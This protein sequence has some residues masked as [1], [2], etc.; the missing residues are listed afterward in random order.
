MKILAGL[1]AGLLFGAGLCISG[2][3]W[4]AKVTGF[5]DFAGAWDP[6][7]AFVMAGAVGTYAIASRII[8]RR[9][10]PLLAESFEPR[11]NNRIDARL[12]VGAGL[13]GVG[14]GLSGYCPGPALVS[15][16]SLAAITLG[17]VGAMSIGM[18]AVRRVMVAA[19]AVLA[20]TT[21]ACSG[22]V[23][24]GV[25]V[26]GPVIGLRYETLTRSGLTT[27]GGEFEYDEGETVTFS[28]G[29]VVLGTTKGAK[30]ISPF[31]LFAVTPPTSP[32]DVRNHITDGVV[33]GFDRAANV[34]LFLQALDNDRDLGNGIDVTAWGAGLA[35]FSL[36]FDESF[37]SFALRTFQDFAAAH[38]GIDRH[39]DVAS[40][41]PHVYT[42]L[43]LAVS[44]RVM[45]T[46]QV[47]TGNDGSINRSFTYGHDA[48]GR[49]ERVQSISDSAPAGDDD[50]TYD[51]RG[52]RASIVLKSDLD[53]NGTFERIESTTWTYDDDGNLV[54]ELLLD[55]T[56]G[57][58]GTKRTRTF[59]HDI[60]GNVVRIVDE[61]DNAGNGSVERRSETTSVYDRKGQRLSTRIAYDNENDGHIDRVTSDTQTFDAHGNVIEVLNTTDS[62]GD[63]AIDAHETIT[64]VYDDADRPLSE[65]SELRVGAPLVESSTRTYTYEGDNLTIEALEL[66][67]DGNGSIDYRAA[68]VRTYDANGRVATGTTS[69]DNDA[70]GSPNQR[71]T[72]TWTYDAS[73]NLLSDVIETDSDG[74]GIPNTRMTR[75]RT[76][77]EL[78]NLTAV[79][80]INDLG[81]D[82]TPDTTS[83]ETRTYVDL[84][85]ALYALVY[86]LVV[87]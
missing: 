13:F 42:T 40:V 53:A 74:D 43:G 79:H 60:A 36:D 14:W 47:D 12:I 16:A 73:Q 5:L 86:E 49:L 76:Y 38:P 19:I 41:L 21:A 20:A 24:T 29:G 17:F 3:T 80:T 10:A 82:G 26:D 45:A 15:T 22:D 11:V 25:F 44:N 77:D 4:P 51:T 46:A 67:N 58:I 87:N 62:D 31:D 85:G 18:F 69:I 34:C 39:I 75:T 78:G 7:L 65:H 72:Q 52:Q 1:I 56:S 32:V 27:A 28:V 33:S 66:D 63:G 64:K 54:T 2:M 71:T 6:S 35:G 37:R 55:T 81:A 57:A 70:D 84:A 23:R 48:L 61:R 9:G 83:L 59:E 68:S 8:R 30:R 50:F